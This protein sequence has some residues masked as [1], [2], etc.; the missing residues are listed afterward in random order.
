MRENILNKL[1]ELSVEEKNILAGAKIDTSAYFS[2]S[3]STINAEGLFG[4]HDVGIRR[5]T[6]FADFPSHKHGYLEVMIV[7][8]GSVVHIVGG[9]RITLA[10]GDIL[11]LNKH[12]E[13]TIMKTEA[14]DIA[15]N[16]SLT[17]SF[18]S[19]AAAQL[20]ETPFFSILTENAKLTGDG[21]YLH[22]STESDIAA[23]NLCENIILEL[24]SC[25][26]DS[27]AVK[28]VE[29][30]MQYLARESDRLLVGGDAPADKR[31]QRMKAVTEYIK[32]SCTRA[33]LTEISEKL[34]LCP[35]Y[36]SKLVKEYFGKSFKELVVD[37][38]MLRA[39][40]LITKTDMNIGDIVRAVGYDNESYFHREFRKRFGETPLTVRKRH[41]NIGKNKT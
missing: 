1:S 23:K 37:E 29:I 7:L 3:D 12:I 26:K 18:L 2:E 35:P 9:D 17:D 11:F 16:V 20:N 10:A 36:L 13:H 38:K 14:E 32:S 5:H 31:A 4:S 41:L 8:S 6:R 40:K 24:L 33:T 21:R 30:L 27:I 22:F 39:H 28:Y 19:V 34:Y 15:V 25:K